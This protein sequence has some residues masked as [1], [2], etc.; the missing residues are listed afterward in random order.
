MDGGVNGTPS[1]T[2]GGSQNAGP[3]G[4]GDECRFL[5]RRRRQVAD[6]NAVEKGA[7]ILRSRLNALDIGHTT[8]SNPV[9]RGAELLRSKPI[10]FEIELVVRIPV[11]TRWAAK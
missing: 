4:G 8:A 10:T 11:S 5:C 9:N 2:L 6:G 3:R 7:E 1:R